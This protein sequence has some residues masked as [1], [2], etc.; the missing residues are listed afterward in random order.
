MPRKSA[1]IQVLDW[2]SPRDLI[3]RGEVSRVK[4]LL[5][6]A[7]DQLT[8]LHEIQAFGWSPSATAIVPVQ[9]DLK[10]VVNLR[11]PNVQT[12][13]QTNPM[14]IRMNFG[15]ITSRP[16]PTQLLGERCAASG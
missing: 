12:V 15:S 2:T 4:N 6:L 7:D 8:C 14:E 5:Y 11:D 10:A 1:P 13:L 16:A 9:F 3:L